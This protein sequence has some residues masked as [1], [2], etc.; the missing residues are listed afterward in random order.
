M[1][2]CCRI[3]DYEEMVNADFKVV[4]TIVCDSCEGIRAG[5]FAV[6]PVQITVVKGDMVWW[7]MGLRPSMA[8]SEYS[9]S[10]KAFKLWGDFM[11]KNIAKNGMPVDS[12][13][14]G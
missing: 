9:I 2:I 5:Y 1:I 3:E 14:V 11:Q 7:S 10:G 4:K 12:V 6:T 13:S 8:F